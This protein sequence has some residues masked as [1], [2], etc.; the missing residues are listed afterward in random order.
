MWCRNVWLNTTQIKKHFQRATNYL[1]H[2]TLRKHLQLSLNFVVYKTPTHKLPQKSHTVAKATYL[3]SSYTTHTVNCKLPRSVRNLTSPH[4]VGTKFNYAKRVP[5]V[6]SAWKR[7]SKSNEKVV[8]SLKKIKINK[9]T[10]SQRLTCTSHSIW[11]GLS[12]PQFIGLVFAVLKLYQHMNRMCE[13]VYP[14]TCPVNL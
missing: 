11:M 3:P 7:K 9:N 6:S 10:H 13:C 4:V 8:H 5:H 2:D 12:L 1:M 14:I